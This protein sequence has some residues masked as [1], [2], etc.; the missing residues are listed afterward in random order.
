MFIQQDRENWI[1]LGEKGN[2]E[3]CETSIQ[4]ALD[5][6]EETVQFD[7]MILFALT[8]HEHRYRRMIESDCHVKTRLVS[9][10]S[11][12]LIGGKNS[13]KQAERA[14]RDLFKSGSFYH[15]VIHSIIH[16]VIHSVIHSLKL[17]LKLTSYKTPSKTHSLL[18][19]LSLKLTHF[20]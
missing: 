14:I 15:S 20:L 16:S 11:L 3:K 1:L 17:S 19:K 10:D 2:V 6:V 7:R 9:E 12:C 8:A 13:V 5:E 18:I 4:D